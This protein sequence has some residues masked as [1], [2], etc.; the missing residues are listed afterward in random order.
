MS[1]CRILFLYLAV[2]DMKREPWNIMRL[3]AQRGY[4]EIAT[5]YIFVEPRRATTRL[6]IGTNRM[7]IV[8]IAAK[9]EPWRAAALRC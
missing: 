2:R 8:C 7:P 1:H 9:I 4:I 6:R 3:M 5:L